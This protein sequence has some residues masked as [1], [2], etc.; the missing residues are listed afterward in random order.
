MEKETFMQKYYSIRVV[1]ANNLSEAIR[2]VEHANFDEEDT[3]CDRVLSSEQ[4]KEI[5]LKKF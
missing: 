1:Q 4:L 3:L 2:E 5:V